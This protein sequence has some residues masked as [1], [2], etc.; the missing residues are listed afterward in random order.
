MGA[1]HTGLSEEWK[2]E[3]DEFIKIPMTGIV[4]SLNLSVSTGILLFEAVRQR[5]IINDKG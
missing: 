5:K 4:D 1:E 2:E 3:A